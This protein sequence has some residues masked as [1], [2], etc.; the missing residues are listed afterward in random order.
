MYLNSYIIIIIVSILYIPALIAR[1]TN[2]NYYDY[3]NYKRWKSFT[4]WLAKKYL[5][6]NNETNTYLTREEIINYGYRFSKCYECII[7]GKCVH[8]GCNAEG[9]FNNKTDFCSND[10]WGSFIKIEDIEEILLNDNGKL[11]KEKLNIIVNE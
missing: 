11:N 2:T 9:R 3:F 4:I 5:K 7:E 6:Y 10:K 8:C 1:Y